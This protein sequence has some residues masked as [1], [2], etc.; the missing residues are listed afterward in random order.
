MRK[1]TRRTPGTRIQN[2]EARLRNARKRVRDLS[3]ACFYFS[4]EIVRLNRV[5]YEYEEERGVHDWAAG[6]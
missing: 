2:V 6:M 1:N 4:K 3:M 5:I